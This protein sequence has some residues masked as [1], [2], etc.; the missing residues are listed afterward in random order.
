M[1]KV[2]LLDSNSLIHRAY[3]ALPYLNN[4]KGQST[5]AI[6]GFLNI[7]LSIIKKE[8]PTHIAA[9]FDLKGPTF[10]NKMYAPYKGTRKPM[11]E[12]LATQ[13]EPVKKLIKLMGIKV[14]SLD[15]YEADDILGTLAKR[16]N[17]DTI[18]V[19]GDRDSFQ[20]ASD[21]TRIYWTKK[22][23]S[24]I[25]EINLE[26]LAEMGFTPSSYIDYKALR[27]DPSDNI[28]GIAGVGEKTAITL[29]DKYKTLDKVLDSAQEI[30]GKI[31][32]TISNSREIAILSRDLATID[33]DVPV[34]CELDEI[35]FDNTFSDAVKSF[36]L[37]LEI[38]SVLTRMK[39]SDSNEKDEK[40]EMEEQP[41]VDTVAIKTEQQFKEVV[42]NVSED[43]SI[44]IGEKIA[45]AFD[46]DTQYLVETAEDLF[47]T[48]MDF[49]SAVSKLKEVAKKKRVV[50]FDLKNLIRKYGFEIENGFDIMVA[51]HLVRG[52][53]T[54]KNI[55]TLLGSERL[56]VNACNIL[57]LAEVFEGELK[58]QDLEKLYNEVEYPLIFVLAKMEERGFSVEM[59]ALEVLEKRFKERLEK[60][61]TEIY[62]SAG[63]EFNIGSPKQMAEVLFEKLNLKSGKKNKTGFS[64]NE[65]VLEKLSDEHPVIP[66]ILE[67]RHLSKLLS[68]YVVGMK[69]LIS[70]GK[71]HTDFNQ[72]ITATGR[73]SSTNPNLQN[74]PV[75][76]VE[77]KEIKSAF[78][79]TG[80]NVLVSADY[81][82]IELRLLAHLSAD[83]GLISQYRS[84]QDIHAATAAQ[85]FGVPQSEVTS[86]M[87]R[88][89]KA[90][91]FGI[92]YGISDFGL[93]KNL[94]IPVWKAKEFIE[95][96]FATYPAVKAYLE[97]NIEFAK[98]NGYAITMLGRRRRLDD[99]NAS[100][101]IVRSSAERMAMNTPL[102]GSSSDIVK[103]AML[104]VEKRLENMKSK[105]ILQV[106]D[107]LIIDTDLAE[108][109]KVKEILLE[110]MQN[111]VELKVPLTANVSS[112]KSWGDVK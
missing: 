27:G 83:E 94:S 5:G 91:N 89:A 16:F 96:Y 22:G 14:V 11:D 103:V 32:E 90:V 81:S 13:F 61:T 68:T 71:I 53:A 46:K 20:L 48:A 34:D 36:L 50:A 33:C 107:E 7:L 112:G 93:S 101:Y 1:S 23:I 55:E 3:H 15:G 47:S 37:E 57:R 82:Q 28:P 17:E 19:T 79:G 95:N 77:A 59:S 78:V 2:I 31:G 86:A 109:E 39:F 25:E 44:C 110:E 43:I 24:E 30:K 67:W 102:Q 76:A 21:S 65:A 29:L 51:G 18:I 58:K 8:Q 104:K 40:I 52:S 42:K 6:Y 4:S 63:F 49:D 75:R 60:L 84:A 80:D 35:V 12:A 41:K 85:I 26:K 98:K 92:V 9:A 97:G 66:L 100:N 62:E 87:R 56:D 38:T 99:I 64:V 106:H 45:F 72:T 73:L 70:H 74:I 108:V 69:P 111:A 88:D 105:M 10:R 54:I